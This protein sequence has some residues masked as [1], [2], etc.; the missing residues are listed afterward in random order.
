MR[1]ICDSLASL[2]S[3]ALEELTIWAVSWN[4]DFLD[5]LEECDCDYAMLFKRFA[6]IMEEKPWTGSKR[7]RLD[8]DK[9]LDYQLILR[10]LAPCDTAGPVIISTG[11]GDF[12][13]DGS[14]GDVG[15][16]VYTHDRERAVNLP[17]I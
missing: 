17:N 8:M 7:L 12:P 15:Y 13:Q 6:S 4:P 14:L 1:A 5:V 9:G 3:S 2:N 10:Q 16:L 11:G